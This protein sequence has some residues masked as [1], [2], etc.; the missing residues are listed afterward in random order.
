MSSSIAE[1]LGSAA[2]AIVD[3]V[4]GGIIGDFTEAGGKVIRTEIGTKLQYA[5]KWAADALD[6]LVEETPHPLLGTHPS[7]MLN[8][9]QRFLK[10]TAYFG[11]LIGSEVAE[12]LFMELIQEGF[13]NAVQTSIGGALQTLLNI[14]R[15]ATPPTPDELDAL[16]P[17]IQDLD[18]DTF[19][20][21]A[22]MTGNNLV[23][24]GVRFSKGFRMFIEEDLK[25]V[26]QQLL[27]VL[28]KLNQ[29]AAWLYETARQLGVEE[30]SE[31]LS[32]IK[33][34]Y[35][36]GIS[37]LDEVAERALSRL[38]EL[39][40]ELETAKEWYQYS[41][42]YP[43]TPI[44]TEEEVLQVAIEN[45]L[46]ADATYNTYQTIKSTIEN[47]LA[48]I[49]YDLSAIVSAIDDVMQKY[50]EHLNSIAE[51]GAVDYSAV[52]NMLKSVFDKIVAYRNASDNVTKLESPIE[53]V[54]EGT[55]LIKVGVYE[56]LATAS[57]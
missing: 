11:L 37:L 38:Q 52:Q 57:Y 22:A 20:V 51:T 2:G 50:A 21:L 36:K 15:G 31:A 3:A 29:A 24:T 39:K 10:A 23:T 30:L 41:Y 17:V 1:L 43:E 33:E 32:V 8:V 13:S 54:T 9:I 5:Y 42:Y 7:G 49:D 27:D 6:S 53:I 45:R 55:T 56:L 12:E 48:T 4:F 25:V 16:V 28:T 19:T 26:K 35:G 47:A 18:E 46:E 34:G 40:T 14:W 44:V